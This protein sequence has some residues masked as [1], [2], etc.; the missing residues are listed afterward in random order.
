MLPEIKRFADRLLHGLR[1][2]AAAGATPSRPSLLDDAH[3]HMGDHWQN[4]LA[5][6]MDARHYVFEDWN[7]AVPAF[8]LA[9][10]H[11]DNEPYTRG[12]ARNMRRRQA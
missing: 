5:S 8:E 1:V 9:D 6:P 2:S 10:V 3:Y 4:L 11:Y 12:E 7:T